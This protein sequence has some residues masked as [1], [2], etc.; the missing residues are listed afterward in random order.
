M[1]R[2]FG[3]Y[4]RLF[5]KAALTLALLIFIAFL[6]VIIVFP[7][8]FIAGKSRSLYNILF[9]ALLGLIFI[10]YLISGFRTSGIS[11]VLIWLAGLKKITAVLFFILILYGIIWIF[12]MHL[13]AAGIILLIS[14][15]FIIGYF[16]F[17]KLK[18]KG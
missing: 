8:W 15:L 10:I 6:S 12:S 3:G 5:K 13:I 11:I 16:E 1:H 18:K 7:L 2:I 14:Y 9:S 17:G 4:I